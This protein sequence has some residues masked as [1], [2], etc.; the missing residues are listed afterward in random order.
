MN[1]LTLADIIRHAQ[2]CGTCA[3]L[4]G[5]THKYTKALLQR[6][7]IAAHNKKPANL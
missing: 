7:I 4:K 5:E 2:T 3:H 6:A 1:Q